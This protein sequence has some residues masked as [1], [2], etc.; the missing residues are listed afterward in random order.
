MTKVIA[1]LGWREAGDTFAEQR[2]E[3]LDRPT[4]GG[5]DEGF[6]LRKAQFDRIEIRAVRREVS[7]CCA[8]GG[9]QP[10]DALDMMR[11]EV[12]SDDDVAWRERRDEDLLDV[13]EK[14]VAVH[15]AIDDAGRGQP[16]DA[17]ARDKRARLPSRQRRMIA[18]AIAAR[19]A[20]ISA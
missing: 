1:A 9:D 12:V 18:D 13:G 15:G 11:G 6:E 20:A 19:A 17:Q 14:T 7:Q 3:R 4:A 2:P 8:G 10:F 16:R 5:A